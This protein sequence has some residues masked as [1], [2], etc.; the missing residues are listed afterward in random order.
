MAVFSKKWIFDPRFPPAIRLFSELTRDVS[1]NFDYPKP[2]AWSQVTP[3]E[4]ASF[5]DFLLEASHHDHHLLRTTT[6][7]T[8]QKYKSYNFLFRAKNSSFSIESYQRNLRWR[9]RRRS[10]G[11]SSTSL[12]R[13]WWSPRLEGKKDRNSKICRFPWLL[14][15]VVLSFYNHSHCWNIREKNLEVMPMENV[16]TSFF[17]YDSLSCSGGARAMPQNYWCLGWWCTS[18]SSTLFIALWRHADP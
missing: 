15:A 2:N 16:V 10:C 14:Y 18:T 13:R 3:W 4:Q 11:S 12:A 1:F 17:K 7:R 6:S 5:P 9:L 8:T